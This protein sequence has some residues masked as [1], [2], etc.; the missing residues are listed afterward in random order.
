MT[1]YVEGAPLALP[2]SGA[3]AE[4]FAGAIDRALDAVGR[5]CA[6]L[7]LAVV[8]LM[9]V[10]VLL[11]YAFSIGSVWAQELEWHLLSPLVL[12]GMT[13]ALQK[14]DHVRV[15]IFY[16]KYSP[17]TQALVDLFSALLAMAFAVL[18]IRY[19]VHF[20]AQS[21][22]VDEISSDPGGLTHRWLLKALIPAGFAL[23]GL[24]AAAQGIRAFLRWK[25][26]A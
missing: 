4:G 25:R 22:A 14:G 10:D 5:A 15:D 13:Y 1:R 23:F 6:W 11:R 18:V 9:A 12:A 7:T 2:D 17:R 21:Y 16:A 20:V 19:S 8:V 3:A 26:A 24:Q